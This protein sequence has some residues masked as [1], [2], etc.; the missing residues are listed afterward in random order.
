MAKIIIEIEDKLKSL[1]QINLFKE[2]KT[3][4]KV[5]TDFIVGYVAKKKK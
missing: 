1:L 2:R 4:K 5:L 3:A